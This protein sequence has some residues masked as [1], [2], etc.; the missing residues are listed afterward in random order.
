M[1]EKRVNKRAA[2]SSVVIPEVMVEVV[3]DPLK[4]Y[5]TPS[6]FQGVIFAC[7]RSRQL[8]K[9]ATPKITAA[10]SFRHKNTTIAIEEIKQGLVSFEKIVED[11]EN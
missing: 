9:G 11:F 8:M 10:E 5:D 1:N 4:I 2:S 7:L 3:R 6:L